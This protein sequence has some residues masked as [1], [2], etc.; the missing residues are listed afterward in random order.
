MF[1]R[2]NSGNINFQEFGSLWNYIQQWQ[3]TFRSYDRDN[4]GNIDKNELKSGRVFMYFFLLS[5]TNFKFKFCNSFF[6]LYH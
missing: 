6:F 1:D 5:Q 3:N 4:S 2:D